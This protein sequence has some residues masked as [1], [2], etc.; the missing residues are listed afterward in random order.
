MAKSRQWSDNDGLKA[1]PLK[2]VG[3]RDDACKILLPKQNLKFLLLRNL[4]SWNKMAAS[5]YY[6]RC[7]EQKRGFDARACSWK[8]VNGARSPIFTRVRSALQCSGN[9]ALSEVT[10]IQP[11]RVVCDWSWFVTTWSIITNFKNTLLW[12]Y[13]NLF[14]IIITIIIMIITIESETCYLRLPIEFFERG[15]YGNRPYLSR[16]FAERPFHLLSMR[17][18]H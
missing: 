13:V 18:C 17:S 10:P 2:V 12:Y 4:D 1:F 15:N 16:I 9:M 6:S 7:L 5:A 8:R 3:K 11:P 14:Y